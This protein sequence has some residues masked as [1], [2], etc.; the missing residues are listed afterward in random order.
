MLISSGGEKMTYLVNGYKVSLSPNWSHVLLWVVYG[1]IL[2]KICKTRKCILQF[3]KDVHLP[4]ART[5]AVGHAEQS[6][7]FPCEIWK[8]TL[9]LRFTQGTRKIT[10]RFD[11]RELWKGI[12]LNPC[13]TR[14]TYKW[15]VQYTYVILTSCVHQLL[16]VRANRP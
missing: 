3:W 16:V 2:I 4:W 9:H 5:V 6:P 13:V 14:S 15:N 10:V 8:R 7:R 1:W 11:L 12:L